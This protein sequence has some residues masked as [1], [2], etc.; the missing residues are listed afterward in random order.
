MRRL[1]MRLIVA[2]T[3]ALFCV[4]PAIAKKPDKPGG[5]GGGGD[6]P[7]G[8]TVYFIHDDAIWTMAPDGSNRAPLLPRGDTWS[9]P[10][11]LRHAGERWF[12][13]R[14]VP[15]SD[16]Q[17]PSGH[18]FVE[19]W[20]TSETGTTVPVVAA[21]DVDVLSPAVWLPDDLSLSFIGE[22]WLLDETGMPTVAVEAGL[23]VVDVEYDAAGGVAGSVPGSL[24]LAADLS[25]ELRTGP[26]G[27]AGN[28]EV[29]G[30]S[31][32]PNLSEF[33]FGVR[34]SDSSPFEQ[35]IW[36]VDLL[37]VSDPYA[38]PATALTL[39]GSGNGIGWPQW[40]PDGLRIGYMSWSGTVIHDLQRGRTNTVKETPNEGWGPS[41]W[42]PD[43]SHF[44]LFHWD[45][46]SGYDGIYRF[47][48]G[49]RG[50][51]ELTAGLCP[52]D[53]QFDCVLIP[54]GWRD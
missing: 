39:L 3:A 19:V 37:Q 41:K 27:F 50:K 7:L 8:G 43:G 5:G 46:A 22:R 53:A 15:D 33:A 16:R 23:Y 49:V 21:D 9:D 42:S 17:F 45:N 2:L 51:T 31:W 26:S 30:H 38:V 10:S 44:V 52:P 6:E 11:H 25:I 13:D 36:I 29:A 35:E 4:A 24:R 47:T 14:T 12:I 40:S 32:S 18:T 28:R 20:A 34:F 48:A 54:L 1:S